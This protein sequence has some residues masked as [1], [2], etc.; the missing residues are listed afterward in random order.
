MPSDQDEQ[1]SAFKTV[2]V[3]LAR[4][5]FFTF[6]AL[7]HIVIVIMAG[8]VVLIKNVAEPPDFEA[9]DGELFSADASSSQP[10][11]VPPEAITPEFTPTSPQVSAPSLQAITSAATTPSSFTMAAAPTLNL[12]SKL[13]KVTESASKGMNEAI[14]KAMASAARAGGKGGFFG[15]S[16]KNVTGLV[17]TF[18]DLKQTPQGKPTEIG[19]VPNEGVDIG[20]PAAA[21]Y[22][23]IVKGFVT[24]GWNVG[25]LSKYF[26]APNKL[27]ATQIFMPRITADEATKAFQVE[28]QCQPRRWIVHYEGTI[29]APKDGRYRFVGLADDMLIVR[30]KGRNVLDGCIGFYR[31]V[32]EVNEVDNMKPEAPGLRAGKWIEMRKG[33]AVKLEILIGE[34]PGGHFSAALMVE[35][36]SAAHPPGAFSV[37]QTAETELPTGNVPRTSGSIIFPAGKKSGSVMDSFFR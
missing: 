33:E 32:P 20:S 11:P 5:R 21:K 9:G 25:L 1:K 7:L 24:G 12:D 17:G 2:Q 6:S 28:G 23:E 27:I 18:Y 26:K 10:P 37:F 22:T 19:P 3:R 4:A 29:S 8:S 15:S 16:D 14:G 36:Q 35:D 31:V 30:C 13:T 34:N